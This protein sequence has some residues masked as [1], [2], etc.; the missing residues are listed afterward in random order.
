VVVSPGDFVLLKRTLKQWF[1][2]SRGSAGS[3]EDRT[4]YDP[5]RAREYE[6]SEIG[7]QYATLIEKEAADKK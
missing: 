3:N 7:S 1:D 4:F 5:K 2:D 6:W